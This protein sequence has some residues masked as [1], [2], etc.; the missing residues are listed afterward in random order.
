MI[1]YASV[2]FLGDD[3]QNL[4]VLR[5]GV[6]VE[7]AVA[8]VVYECIAGDGR[9]RHI[10]H[11]SP[12]V[13]LRLGR[14]CV[15]GSIYVYFLLAVESELDVRHGL[16]SQE[17]LPLGAPASQFT[18]TFS[19]P[20]EELAICLVSGH[21]N[22]CKTL[23]VLASI[24]AHLNVLLLHRRVRSARSRVVACRYQALWDFRIGSWSFQVTRLRRLDVVHGSLGSLR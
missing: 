7:I 12:G 8:E 5:A 9:W 10:V 4:V 3:L 14:I 24:D 13:D 21:V 19:N 22:L 2:Q 6:A 16:G 17:V 15:F 23:V 20:A 1:R 18:I 11:V